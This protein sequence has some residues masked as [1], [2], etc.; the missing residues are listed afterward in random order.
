VAAL[1]VELD[2]SLFRFLTVFSLKQIYNTLTLIEIFLGLAC[3]EF[4][5]KPQ[6]IAN[7]VSVL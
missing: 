3:Y 6:K 4:D 1:T 7:K 2:L 5:A